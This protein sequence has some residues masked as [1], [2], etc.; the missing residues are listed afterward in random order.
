[1]TTYILLRSNR[2]SGPFTLDQLLENGLR[3]DDLIWVEGQSA[4]WRNPHEIR[5]LS[6]LAPAKP[7]QPATGT[8]SRSNV[9]VALPGR[10]S[11]GSGKTEQAKPV[12]KPS[13]ATGRIKEPVEEKPKEELET[14]Y[15]VSLD[16][17]KQRYLQTLESKTRQPRRATLSAGI[18][19]RIKALAMY[20]AVF[21]MGAAIVFLLVRPTEVLPVSTESSRLPGPLEVRPPEEPLVSESPEDE[22]ML[23]E[24]YYETRETN[25][26]PTGT[27]KPVHTVSRERRST[28]AARPPAG[29]DRQQAEEPVAE[30]TDNPRE[31]NREVQPAET[32]AAEVS[33]QVSVRTNR[34]TIAALGGIRDLELTL[35]N[36]SEFTL[37]RV[38]VEVRYLSPNGNVVKSEEVHFR[39]I[40]PS[41]SQTVSMKKTSRGVKVAWKIRRIESREA[42]IITAGKTHPD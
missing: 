8:G 25:P 11:Q 30:T 39:S 5:E 20:A 34:Y 2:E 10:Q 37:D 3:P 14:K 17:I 29:N 13:P 35:N 28:E 22:I 4:S 1:M 24:S 36:D 18:P 40:H 19:P 6:E 32:S 26:T 42:G 41:G 33:S 16:D 21:I 12:E 38:T 15:A 27:E 9:F 7:V 31:T 23:P